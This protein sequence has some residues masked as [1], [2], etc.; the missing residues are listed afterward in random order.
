VIKEGT[1]PK[2]TKKESV[3]F[4]LSSADP[5]S[6]GSVSYLVSYKEEDDCIDY[7]Q[8]FNADSEKAWL[9]IVKDVSAFANTWGGYLVFGISDSKRELVGL[10]R[11]VADV[12]KDANTILQK[13]NRHLEPEIISLRSK[14][15][16]F[17][18]KTIVT[19]YVP[20]STGTTHM[21]SK[22]GEFKYSSQVHLANQLSLYCAEFSILIFKIR[23]LIKIDCPFENS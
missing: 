12:L 5:L 10:T 9:E 23:L 7:K 16:R 15:Y 3:N 8:T 1:I 11:H 4:H 6:R 13:I 20:Q 18:G 19:A 17:E 14:E 21:I 2:K 22:D